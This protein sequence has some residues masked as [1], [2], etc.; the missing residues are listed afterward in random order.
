MSTTRLSFNVSFNL[1]LPAPSLAAAPIVLRQHRCPL[2]RAGRSCVSRSALSF[3]PLP[4]LP[5]DSQYLGHTA[6]P[7]RSSKREPANYPNVSQRWRDVPTEQ[8]DDQQQEAIGR[9]PRRGARR[10]FAKLS[11]I[12]TQGQTPSEKSNHVV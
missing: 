7:C 5:E 1:G 9:L 8:T 2:R 12:G 3:G 10:F 4:F 11:R 6:R